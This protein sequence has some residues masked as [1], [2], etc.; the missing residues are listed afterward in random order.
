MPKVPAESRESMH[1]NLLRVG[2]VGCPGGKR[3]REAESDATAGSTWQGAEECR[4][5]AES[6]SSHVWA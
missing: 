3:E 1:T 5:G 6:S 4:T 2:H